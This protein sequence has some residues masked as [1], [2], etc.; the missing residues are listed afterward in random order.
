MARRRRPRTT[1]PLPPPLPPAR[2]TVGQLV[3]EAIRAYGQSFWKALALGIPVAV[4][5]GVVWRL[6]REGQ[7]VAAPLGGFLITLSYVAA[8]ALV[9]G[10]RLRSRNALVAYVAGVLVFV[11]FPFLAA[12]YILPGLVWLALFGLAVP[13][14]LV[15]GLGLR[16]AIVRGFRLA[17]ADFVH[18]LGGIATLALLVFLTQAVL[19]F[20]LRE[21]AE[22]TRIAAA[23]LASLVVSPLLF[24]GGALLYVDQEA[25]LRSQ[26]VRGKERDADVSHA[27]EAHGER[28][29]DTAR[30][31]RPSA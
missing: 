6:S 19:F 4:V 24:L 7:L 27:D 22:N 29:P 14:A 23:T 21:Y 31:S 20:V 18:V 3:G 28:G 17:R 30:Q 12:I 11:P 16:G 25:R 15:E 8:C 9:T 1:R 13:A 26:L 2:R 10:S 5:N